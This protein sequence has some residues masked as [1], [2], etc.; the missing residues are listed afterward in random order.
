MLAGHGYKQGCRNRI[1]LKV[2]SLRQSVRGV[3][4][5]T[6]VDGRVK[7]RKDATVA[8]KLTLRSVLRRRY[9]A[10]MGEPTPEFPT[11]DQV[12]ELR[13]ST[14]QL[15]EQLQGEFAP[16]VVEFAGSPKSGKT[17][18]I[19]IV[20]HFYKRLGFSVYAPSE[21]ASKRTPYHLRRDLTAFNSWT[22]N[23][24]ISELLVAYHNVDRFDLIFLDRGPFDSLA[25][26]GVLEK[27]GEVSPEDFAVI[28][29]FALLPKW[30]EIVTR[31]Y[32]FT[33]DTVLSLEREHEAK[34]IRAEGTA[35]NDAMLTELRQ[36][37]EILASELKQF[38]LKS[39][40]TS[41]E[42][43]PKGTSYE[44]ASDIRDLFASR[45]SGEAL[46]G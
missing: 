8:L 22:L 18:T 19:E 30:S 42:T 1:N 37:Y 39:V 4:S 23:Y 28:K 38:P 11:D 45:L 35:M 31:L 16:V 27:R 21:G 46:G 36:E 41:L 34:L 43:T 2:V 17:T 25:W 44:V 14:K 40:E 10:C 20:S 24:A 12:A 6:V 26:M 13:E 7:C 33:C 15:Q 29:Q 3:Q 32:L 9:G 5:S